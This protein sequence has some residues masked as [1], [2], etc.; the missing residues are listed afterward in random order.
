M[1]L[2]LCRG[3]GVVLIGRR[4]VDV[5]LGFVAACRNCYVRFEGDEVDCIQ[6]LDSPADFDKPDPAYEALCNFLGV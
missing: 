3:T 1:N 4:N 5:L 6:F 2:P